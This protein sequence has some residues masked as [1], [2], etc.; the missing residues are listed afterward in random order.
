MTEYHVPVLLKESLEGL[1][2][3]NGGIYVD[4]TFGGGG[5]SRAILKT[6]KD[7]K[8][9][10]FDQDED[11]EKISKELQKEYS[12]FVFIKDNFKNI[13]TGLS[14]N[15]IK[16]IDGII[17]D[18]GVSSHQIDTAKR[19]FSFMQDGDLDMRMDKTSELSA[20]EVINEYSKEELQDIF[21]K[22]GEEREAF[23]IARAI[24]EERKKK[25]IKTTSQLAEIID[26]SIH[27][28]HRIKAKARIFQAIRIYVNKEIEA[29]NKALKDS[30]HILNK[31]GRIV[32]ISY[33]SIEDRVVKQFFKYENLSCVCPPDYPIC[34][35]GKVSTL[36]IITKKPII[37]TKEE[38]SK[39]KRAKSAKLRIAERK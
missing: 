24:V 30:V 32:V 19:G 12:N 14:L 31:G 8:L 1:N 9:F 17:F 28:H 3:V 25:Y 26:R 18:L 35:C 15:R 7:I 13:R 4:A 33:H 10:A 34:T 22:Y 20:A 29:L 11:A 16:K 2:I 38:I 6:G 39:N 5:H 23:R 27:S 21:Y 36:K 37:P